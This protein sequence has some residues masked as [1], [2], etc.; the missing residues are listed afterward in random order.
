MIREQVA[1]L[2][3]LRDIA[4]SRPAED[5]RRSSTSSG[6]IH[7]HL[8]A[9]QRHAIDVIGRQS[10]SILPTGLAAPVPYDAT[11]YINKQSGRVIETLG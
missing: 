4:T 5:Q 8:S 7:G 10:E 1:H 11:D 6:R 9:V 2:V 3:R